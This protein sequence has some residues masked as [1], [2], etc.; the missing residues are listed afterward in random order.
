[1]PLVEL[2][3]AESPQAGSPP[4]ASPVPISQ[5]LHRTGR[6]RP[7]LL[8]EQQPVVSQQKV[9][10]QAEQQPVGFP[11]EQPR[12]GSQ[13]LERPQAE[14]PAFPFQTMVQQPSVFQ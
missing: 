4:E 12:A 1:L 2:L 10:P 6:P 13:S 7:F 8:P 3:P 14:R 9:L 5:W 11:E